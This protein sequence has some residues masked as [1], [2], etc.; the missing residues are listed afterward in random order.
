GAPV[1]AAAA[2][3][4]VKNGP[5]STSAHYANAQQR[6]VNLPPI[7]NGSGSGASR[8]ASTVFASGSGNRGHYGSVAGCFGGSFLPIV[9]GSGDGSSGNSR[10]RRMQRQYSWEEDDFEF[11]RGLMDDPSGG[12]G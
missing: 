11:L 1:T 10:R 2:D 3:S 7:L 8:G 9:G 12:G 4:R 5:T 6:S